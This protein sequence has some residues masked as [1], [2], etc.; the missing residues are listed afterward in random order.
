M[1]EK[2]GEPKGRELKTSR[3]IIRRNYA[4]HGGLSAMFSRY[5]TF[6]ASSTGHKYS[7]V[8]GRLVTGLRRTALQAGD[9]ARTPGNLGIIDASEASFR[10]STTDAG[11]R[12]KGMS[13]KSTPAPVPVC[14]LDT[15]MAILVP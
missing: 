8:H 5:L 1:K 7:T 3:G 11:R 13:S 10:V 2:L 14:G 9:T 6:A 12:G 4:R 15:E